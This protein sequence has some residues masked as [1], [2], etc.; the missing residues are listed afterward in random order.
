MNVVQN[1]PEFTDGV[2][3]IDTDF[4]VQTINKA[5]AKVFDVTPELF[6][7][8]DAHDLFVEIGAN[9]WLSDVPLVFGSRNPISAR[10]MKLSR[11]GQTLSLDYRIMPLY[12]ERNE[13][14]GVII[15]FHNVTEK[16]K[17]ELRF[18]HLFER[19]NDGI[20]VTD[21]NLNIIAAN[22]KAL[23]IFGIS[24]TKDRNFGEF[25][26]GE[27][28]AI[29]RNRLSLLLGGMETQP[30][31]II[32][33]DGPRPITL[34][35]NMSAIKEY[36]NLIRIQFIVRDITQRIKLEEQLIQATKM[37][38][39]GEMAAGFAHEINNPIATIAASSEEIIDLMTELGNHVQSPLKGMLEQLH[40]YIQ[41][42]CYRCKKISDDLLGFARVRRPLTHAVD[43]NQTVI[44]VVNL[45]GLAEKDSRNRIRLDLDKDLPILKSNA[46]YLQQV[47]LNLL[48]NA[49]DATEGKG[50]VTIST[51]HSDSRVLIVFEDTGTGISHEHLARLF[52]PFFTTKPPT[53]GTGLGLAISYRIVQR[54][55]GS[56][57]VSSAEGRGSVFTVSL[58]TEEN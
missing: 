11:K 8:K 28:H 56:I 15:I 24:E 38:A 54:L 22:K 51:R 5:M 23:T 44:K 43:V 20:L 29:L 27:N 13:Q 19:A 10:N 14:Y 16:E 33:G 47:F 37:S 6:V 32:S 17:A 41:E 7:K 52:D 26:T 53:K 48:N 49:L 3:V 42:Q 18:Q 36:A 55:S 46:S 45:A 12:N 4:K 34:E 58:P 39:L 21:T 25:F 40:S 57:Q 9:E 30:Y 50:S 35:I 1:V 2:A 31:E